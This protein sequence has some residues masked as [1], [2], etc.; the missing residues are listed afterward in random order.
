M[1]KTCL[2]SQWTKCVLLWRRNA[3]LVCRVASGVCCSWTK[4]RYIGMESRSPC[5]TTCGLQGATGKDRRCSAKLKVKAGMQGIRHSA[6]A[7]RQTITILM[8]QL[9]H[10]MKISGH[11]KLISFRRHC[12]SR[13]SRCRLQMLESVMRGTYFGPARCRLREDALILMD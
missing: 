9:Y 8:M 11:A 10:Y 5:W 4:V 2:L 7:G 6:N 12:F 3:S 13:A 1:P